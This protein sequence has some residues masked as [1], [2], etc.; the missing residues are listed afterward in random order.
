M[1]LSIRSSKW[2]FDAEEGCVHDDTSSQ[3]SSCSEKYNN[4]KYFSASDEDLVSSFEKEVNCISKNQK[5]TRFGPEGSMIKNCNNL[6]G[7]D[8]S[9]KRKA[10]MVR[11]G[12][13]VDIRS[14]LLHRTLVEEVNKLRLFKTVGAVENIGFHELDSGDRRM[15]DFARKSVRESGKRGEFKWWVCFKNQMMLRL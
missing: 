3:S 5:C 1:I 13:M 11:S 14:Q 7:N 15:N 4:L 2:E 8:C 9:S 10:K 12:S 6:N